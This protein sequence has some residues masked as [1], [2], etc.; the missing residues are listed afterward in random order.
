MTSHTIYPHW[1]DNPPTSAMLE[2]CKLL[3]LGLSPL[4]LV[5][6]AGPGACADYLPLCARITEAKG[7]GCVLR[8]E[9]LDGLHPVLV[10]EVPLFN[11]IA[12]HKHVLLPCV[13]YDYPA[14][15]AFLRWLF[16]LREPIRLHLFANPLGDMHPGLRKLLPPELPEAFQCPNLDM[17]LDLALHWSMERYREHHPMIARPLRKGE[18]PITAQDLADAMS[19]LHTVSPTQLDISTRR[20]NN[21]RGRNPKP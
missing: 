4:V 6:G 11:S 9:W 17:D 13:D 8:S 7:A 12:P 19:A 16:D 3:D 10:S 20:L 5:P 15:G 2:A 18:L 14:H 21:L 1:T